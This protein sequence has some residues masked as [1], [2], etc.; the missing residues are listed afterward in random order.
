MNRLSEDPEAGKKP[1]NGKAQ[2]ADAWS[3]SGGKSRVRFRV[4]VRGLG[5]RVGVRGL[6]FRV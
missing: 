6:G 1:E 3:W 2:G 4:G 5:F